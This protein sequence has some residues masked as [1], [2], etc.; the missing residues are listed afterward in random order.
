M[1]KRLN[2]GALSSMQKQTQKR[3]KSGFKIDMEEVRWCMCVVY[4]LVYVY[5]SAFLGS[6]LLTPFRSTFEVLG[7]KGESSTAHRALS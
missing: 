5:V 6:L 3:L 1:P 4:G 7:W 2:N